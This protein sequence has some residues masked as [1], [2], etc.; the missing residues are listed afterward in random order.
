M[1]RAV[2]IEAF[3]AGVDPALLTRGFRR[4]KKSQEWVRDSDEVNRDSIHINFGLGIVNP[5]VSVQ[6]RDLAAVVPQAFGSCHASAMLTQLVPRRPDYSFETNAAELTGDIV[7]YGLPYL[8]RLHD[9]EFAIRSLSSSTPADWCTFSYSHRIRLQ[10]LLLVSV[11]R[12]AEA[13][14]FVEQTGPESAQKDQLLPR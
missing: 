11:G 14:K 10:P 1:A 3:L 4:R 9:R 7:E 8:S 2:E 13:I 5:S 12:I 6:Y